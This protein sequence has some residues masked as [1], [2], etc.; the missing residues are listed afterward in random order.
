MVLRSIR[1]ATPGAPLP[2][3]AAGRSDRRTPPPREPAERRDAR[4]RKTANGR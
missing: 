3:P 1:T 4:H 2:A